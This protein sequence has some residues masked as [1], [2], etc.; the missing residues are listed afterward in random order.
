MTSEHLTQ[1]PQ[2]CPAVHS[3]HPEMYGAPSETQFEALCMYID[4][5]EKFEDSTAGRRCSSL[6]E[7]GNYRLRK[8]FDD[9][10]AAIN[11][12]LPGMDEGVN[13]TASQLCG[14]DFWS[15]LHRNDR[16]AAGICLAFMVKHSMVP[17]TMHRTRSGK[18]KKKYH[19]TP[20][21]TPI[22]RSVAVA[23]RPASNIFN[24]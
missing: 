19:L 7:C 4:L 22:A 9:V 24:L 11:D 3:T 14:A 10:Y 2:R 8:M 12:A 6:L 20:K 15:G 17:L 13:Y 23:P 16:S 21:R 5:L 1:T 18:G